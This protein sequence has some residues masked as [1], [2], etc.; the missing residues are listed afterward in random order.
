MMANIYRFG[1]LLVLLGPIIFIHCTQTDKKAA[2]PNEQ[3]SNQAVTGNTSQAAKDTLNQQPDAANKY[4]FVGKRMFETEKGVQGA[5]TPHRY[6]E[7]ME[8][9]GVY[10]GFVQENQADGEMMEERY[11]A[12]PYAEYLKCE[13]KKLNEVKYYH[14]TANK[15]VLVDENR[16][17][18]KNNACCGLG[19]I[20]DDA[21]CP[22]ESGYE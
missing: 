4:P 16:N 12:G 2:A 1:F 13:F 19:V 3:A 7:V 6:I 21:G 5:G 9:G 10:F 15:I 20:D 8:N 18:V 22:C 11:F 14:L 17:P